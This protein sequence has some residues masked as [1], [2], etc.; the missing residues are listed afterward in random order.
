MNVFEP[1]REEAIESWRKW[2]NEEIR[3]VYSSENCDNFK[4]N[5][6]GE[7]CSTY[8]EKINANGFFLRRNLEDSG[9]RGRIILISIL[10]IRW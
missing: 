9:V 8:G 5:F 7:A 1:K 4:E 10:K 6:V 3:D 2:Q